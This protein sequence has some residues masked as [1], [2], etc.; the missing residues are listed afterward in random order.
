MSKEQNQYYKDKVAERT[1]EEGRV[2]FKQEVNKVLKDAKENELNHQLKSIFQQVYKVDIKSYGKYLNAALQERD[3]F[4]EK[5]GISKE[6]IDTLNPQ[7]KQIYK[8]IMLKINRNYEAIQ[9][10]ETYYETNIKEHYP[11]F[12]VEEL[13]KVEKEGLSRVID[14]YGD[15]LTLES[16]KQAQQ[17]NILSKY[18]YSDRELGMEYIKKINEGTMTD[19]DW[20]EVGNNFKMRELFET[21][22]DDAS[23]EMF[24]S[25]V[26]R[27][28]S[29]NFL[30]KILGSARILE[31]L[32]KASR[33]NLYR[34][35]NDRNKKKLKEGSKR[36]ET[37]KR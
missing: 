17:G 5:Q 36:V 16:I 15:R 20:K 14:Y 24:L 4:L 3:Q 23:R 26:D 7:D 21:V 28:R 11:S 32:E 35:N 27:D 12:K 37:Y 6:E 1:L 29:G 22:S 18:S 9:I 19:E 13:S 25:D 2:L 34:I 8:K 10:L 31:N 30:G 33:D